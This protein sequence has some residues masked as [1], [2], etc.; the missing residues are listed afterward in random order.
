M[1]IRLDQKSFLMFVLKHSVF[2]DDEDDYSGA[3]PNISISSDQ[4]LVF[5]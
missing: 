2:L 1:Y 5:Y 3:V 4:K